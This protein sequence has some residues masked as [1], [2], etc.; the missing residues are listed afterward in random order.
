MDF[1]F[2]FAPFLKEQ[3]YKPFWHM[4]LRQYTTKTVGS[5]AELQQDFKGKY[6]APFSAE[7]EADL[8]EAVGNTNECFYYKCRYDARLLWLRKY[9]ENRGDITNDEIKKT[10]I[11]AF[12]SSVMGVADVL[13]Q[14]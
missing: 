1:F 10:F 12:Q 8:D 14:V 6:M 4:L 7:F 2:N 9:I 13:N 11:S 3:W 5:L